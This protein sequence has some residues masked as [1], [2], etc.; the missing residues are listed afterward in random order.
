MYGYVSEP[1][2]M[3]T[4]HYMAGMNGGHKMHD[5]GWDK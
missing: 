1:Y 4:I 5:E 3:Y 2:D